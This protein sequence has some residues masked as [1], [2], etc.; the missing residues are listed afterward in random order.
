MK[1]PLNILAATLLAGTIFSSSISP[2]FAEDPTPF[3]DVN[4]TEYSKAVEFL[5]DNGITKGISA[6]KFGVRDPITRVNAAVILGKYL[7]VD[8]SN[9][10]IPK[11]GFRD[12]PPRAVNIVSFLKY[13]G[14]MNGK[15]DTYFGAGDNITRGEAAIMLYRAFGYQ[16]PDADGTTSFT[17]ISP[18]YERA[19]Q[20]L[21][22]KGVILGIN[23]TKFGTNDPL[24]RG[25]LALLMYRISLLPPYSPLP[26]E[27]KHGFVAFGDSN[28]EGFY[29][30]KQFPE[31]LGNK[32]TD[33]VAAVYG[34]GINS[35]IYNAGVRGNTTEQGAV[36][37]KEKVLDVNPKAVTIMFGINDALL[38]DNGQPQVSKVIFKQ[39]LTSMVFQLKARDIEVVLM[40][41]PPVIEG[42]YYNSQIVTK[43]KNIAP[44][45]TDKDGLR[46]WIN[47]YNDI[48]RQVAKDQGV[49]LVDVHNI[50]VEKAGGATD[51]LL[52][53]SGLLD[54]KTG[55]HMTPKANDIIA[56]HVKNKLS[57]KINSNP[58][59]ELNVSIKVD[60]DI[61]DL[62]T[63]KSIKITISNMDS[64]SYSYS[65]PSFLQKK[66][67]NQWVTVEYS[68]ELAF[69]GIVETLMPNT[70]ATAGISLDARSFKQP[71]TAGVY[72]VAHPLGK[73]TDFKI[74]E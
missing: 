36:R 12:L 9:P 61:Y 8:Q 68:D 43:N 15:T 44:L 38:L 47:S 21:V 55:I 16:L 70:T 34:E 22:N 67:D 31:S 39:N 40:T 24:T 17:D 71:L 10:N 33:Q 63:D 2:A 14:I 60:K 37:F 32:W 54:D 13:N 7:N 58:S 42:I 59:D 46:N 51:Y 28:T 20:A 6:T 41:N 29:F 3:T 19:V 52:G 57:D 56:E 30:E 18:R 4:G 74:V 62:S 73:S 49:P 35:T 26:A 66:L 72:R 23:D 25:Q 11:S 64:K 1:K 45:Y 65:P 27:E 48:I 50:L 53:S 69:P 5:Y